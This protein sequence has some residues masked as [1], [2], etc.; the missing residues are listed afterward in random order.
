MN[1]KLFNL[2]LNYHS[3]SLNYRILSLPLERTGCLTHLHLAPPPIHFSG[4][5]PLR[6]GSF[7]SPPAL[8]QA[9]VSAS[10]SYS[11]ARKA[12]G[13]T[14]GVQFARVLGALLSS[15]PRCPRR[16]VAPATVTTRAPR[17]SRGTTRY[18][19]VPHLPLFARPRSSAPMGNSWYSRR[20]T[21]GWV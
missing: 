2:C 1:L 16:R 5:T 13:I 10:L 15:R 14:T 3:L 6:V 18:G 9:N 19:D 8:F 17:G 20:L 21:P 11:V 4:Q 7:P 12:R